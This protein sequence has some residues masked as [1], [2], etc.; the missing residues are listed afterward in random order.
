MPDIILLITE[1]VNTDTE[2]GGMAGVLCD[3]LSGGFHAG[4]GNAEAITVLTNPQA[5][6]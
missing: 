3:P 4:R 1:R 2:S 5:G 6:K